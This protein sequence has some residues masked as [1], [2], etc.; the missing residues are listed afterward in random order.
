MREFLRES[1]LTNDG[2]KPSQPIKSNEK[3]LESS[4]L[5]GVYKEQFRYIQQLENMDFKL[6]VMVIAVG[7][8]LWVL[9][10]LPFVEMNQHHLF[11]III[12]LTLLSA[13]ANHITIKH[14]AVR[15]S[16]FLT[17][18][19][20]EKALGLRNNNIIPAST[21]FVLP[22]SFVD[23]LTRFL[24]SPSGPKSLVYSTIMG[25]AIIEIQ[26][27]LLHIHSISLVL[28]LDTRQLAG[29]RK[30]APS[31]TWWGDPRYPPACWGECHSFFFFC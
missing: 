7:A 14:A 28:P 12:I 8:T 6:F 26:W 20:I 31:V 23:F 21:H 5:L 9:A 27:D 24:L 25:M 15:W 10:A 19:Q 3:S 16:R 18:G 22:V 13:A 2:E 30:A 29:G 17:L 4:I 1:G 11:G